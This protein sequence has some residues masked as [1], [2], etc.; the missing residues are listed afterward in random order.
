MKTLYYIN[1]KQV[2]INTYYSVSSSDYIRKHIWKSCI[3]YYKT[4]PSEFEF[5]A[6]F[7]NEKDLASSLMEAYERT[8]DYKEQ[9]KK[10]NSNDKGCLIIFLLILEFPLTLVLQKTG[11]PLIVTSGKLK[12]LCSLM[13]TGATHNV[14]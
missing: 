6:R 9:M 14:Y 2:D 3:S 1:G 5:I 4:H 12:N 13:D 8:D 10:I 7:S 11:L